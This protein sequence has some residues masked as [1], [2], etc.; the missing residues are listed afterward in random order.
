MY[1][2]NW[3]YLI[4]NITRQNNYHYEN[5]YDRQARIITEI[6]NADKVGKIW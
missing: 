1:S 3:I 5:A 2:C 4:Y 6:Q